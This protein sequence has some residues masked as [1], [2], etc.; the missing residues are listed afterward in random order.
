MSSLFF[1][2]QVLHAQ[3]EEKNIWIEGT[4][5]PDS[6]LIESGLWIEG[7]GSG[8]LDPEN[9]PFIPS[10][11]WRWFIMEQ[12]SAVLH[13]PGQLET[14]TLSS[15]EFCII[16]PLPNN[17]MVSFELTV[18]SRVLCLAMEGPL[19]P[20][21]LKRLGPFFHTS[22]RQMILPSQLYVANQIV[23]VAVR[24]SGT[25]NA[26]FHLQQLLWALLACKNG[27]PVALNA[28]LSYEISKVIDTLRFNEYKDNYS[29]ADMAAIA[30]L[31]VE[32]FRKRFNSEIGMPPLSYLL[33][34][35]MEKAKELL[36]LYGSVKLASESIGMSDPYHFS[37]QFKNTV[38]VSPS[39]YAKQAKNN[40]LF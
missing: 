18:A 35:K 10:E 9:Y 6:L 25:G 38:G 5:I 36:A 22:I 37:K 7:A 34:S 13:A 32:T 15:G 14:L 20:L 3:S 28:M 29:L 21:Y 27:Q 40:S 31:P 19:V 23:Q 8:V 30:K 11:C 2:P 17:Q 1:S 33:F 24:H 39:A 12:G 26:S 4:H 16:P